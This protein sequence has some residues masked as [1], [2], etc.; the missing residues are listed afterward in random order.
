MKLFQAPLIAVQSLWVRS[1]APCL[2]AAV[3]PNDGSVPA[4]GHPSYR[5]GVVGES[6]AASV[7]AESHEQGIPGALARFVS[8]RTQRRVEWVVFGARNATIRRVREQLVPQLP[9]DLDLVVLLT[10]LNDALARVALETWSTDVAATIEDLAVRNRHVVVSG[11][12]PVRGCRSLPEPLVGYLDERAGLMDGITRQI[13]EDRA[14]VTF[15]ANRKLFEA[16][17][18]VMFSEGLNPSKQGYE[19]WAN[20]L[21][22]LVVPL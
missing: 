12:P 17:P 19:L 20:S 1:M 21:A 3:G 16:H 13:C 8:A 10:G 11:I 5:L 22:Q 6:T 4:P 9:S 7:G 2:P 18:D 14:D 15:A